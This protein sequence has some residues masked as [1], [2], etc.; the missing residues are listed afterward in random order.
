MWGVVH[1]TPNVPEDEHPPGG[2]AAPGGADSQGAHGAAPGGG[3][4]ASSI[5]AP[6]SAGAVPADAAETG[7]EAADDDEDVALLAR[8]GIDGVLARLGHEGDDEPVTLPR[9]GGRSPVLS[10]VVVAVGI[11][12][13]VTMWPDFRYWLRSDTPEDLGHA[14]D[15]VRDGTM[16][17]GLDNHFVRLRGT[18]DVQ[19]AVRLETKKRFIG[20]RRIVEAG[21]SLF[22]AIPR[23]KSE[24]VTNT[25]EGAFEG[26]MRRL[27]DHG[28]Y[29]WLE[30]F[31]EREHLVRV[32]DVT[33]AS[34]VAFLQGG[35]GDLDGSD[36]P[37]TPQ[38][39]DVLRVVVRLPVAMVQVGKK[40]V[41]GA[42]EA[43][44]RVASLGRPFGELSSDKKPYRV[45]VVE[46]EPDALDA[47]AARLEDGL[48]VTNRADP[49]QGV[50][51]LPK[52]ATYRVRPSDLR[53]E[54]GRLVFPYGDNKAS[55]GF[56]REGDRLV[57]KLPDDGLLRIPVEW[58]TAIR[59]ERPIRLDPDGYVLLHGERPSSLR[60]QGILWLVVF[61]LVTVNGASFFLWWRRRR[62]AR[63]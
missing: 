54:D 15:L 43:R 26:R 35:R 62:S 1:G 11:F 44:A 51:V 28:A 18:P 39:G 56:V 30:T 22:V 38:A 21:G 23:P 20:Y 48:T 46:A 49:G 45:F 34:V 31:F 4:D 32:V 24:T 61:G 60:M 3:G 9:R 52:L 14:A 55:P 7:A 58:V 16:P 47:M 63:A 33:P 5:E 8:H 36:G 59:L 53:V 41:P 13:L 10:L 57:E 12:M 42:D 40:S 27:G 2:G 6:E 19:N 29:P 25:F 17:P 50:A 37:V